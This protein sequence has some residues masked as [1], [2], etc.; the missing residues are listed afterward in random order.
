MTISALRAFLGF[1]N[2]YSSYINGYAEIA[3][4]FQEKLKVPRDQ[5]KKGSKVRIVWSESDVEAFE[6]LKQVL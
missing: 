5:G 1:A 3:A 4:P 6:A 2:Y